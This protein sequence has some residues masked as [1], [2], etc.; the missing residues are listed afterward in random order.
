MPGGLSSDQRR[1]K[2]PAPQQF[3]APVHQPDARHWLIPLGSNGRIWS[4][5]NPFQEGRLPGRQASWKGV[6]L[7]G[8]PPVVGGYLNQFTLH[9]KQ[10]EGPTL[11]PRGQGGCLSRFSRSDWMSAPAKRDSSATSKPMPQKMLRTSAAA[12]HQPADP[13]SAGSNTGACWFHQPGPCGFLA[14]V[15]PVHA[16]AHAR[17]PRRRPCCR[18]RHHLLHDG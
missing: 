4:V 13:R 5:A 12:I 16:R 2:Q 17:R 14:D 7:E 9:A 11:T 1:V 3:R 6:L 8:G 15:V 10:R 18:C